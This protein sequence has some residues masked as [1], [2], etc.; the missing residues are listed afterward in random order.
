MTDS[1]PADSTA[2]VNIQPVSV[3]LDVPHLFHARGTAIIGLRRRD[4]P[5]G[6]G[7]G[8]RFS[9]LMLRLDS[10]KLISSVSALE[11]FGHTSLHQSKDLSRALI[12]VPK[13]FFQSISSNLK[14][15][16]NLGLY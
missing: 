3:L 11:A 15:P 6:V 12:E 4:N 2:L 7:V 9:F 1:I 14:S 13:P 10:S 16:H 8:R 5:F